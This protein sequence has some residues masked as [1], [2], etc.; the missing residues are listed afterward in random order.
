MIDSPVTSSPPT[1]FNRFGSL[2]EPKFRILRRSSA[3]RQV[4]PGRRLHAVRFVRAGLK[5]ANSFEHW[6]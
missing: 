2:E 5:A 3:E 1:L 4:P 6:F